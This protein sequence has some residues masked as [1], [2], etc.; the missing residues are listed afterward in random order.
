MKLTKPEAV[1][2]L[3]SAKQELDAASTKEDFV[4]VLASAGKKVGYSPAFRC[5]VNGQDAEES[6]RWY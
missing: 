5:L 1:A 6:V 2:I 4:N 3:Q